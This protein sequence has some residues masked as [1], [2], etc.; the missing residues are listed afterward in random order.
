MEDCVGPL[1]SLWCGLFDGR[2]SVVRRVSKKVWS[3]DYEPCSFLIGSLVN[4]A[5]VFCM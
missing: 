1:G 4:I 5:S 3:C 2:G